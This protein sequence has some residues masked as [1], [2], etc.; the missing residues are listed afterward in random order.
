MA[1]D[2][3]SMTLEADSDRSFLIDQIQKFKLYMSSLKNPSCDEIIN[4]VR[5]N[6]KQK[7]LL[8]E[9][10][11]YIKKCVIILNYIKLRVIKKFLIL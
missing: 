3:V 2:F 11:S 1:G 10:I 9:R 7:K 4:R 5:S 8:N 6:S